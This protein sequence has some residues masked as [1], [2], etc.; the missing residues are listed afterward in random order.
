MKFWMKFIKFLLK[1]NRFFKSNRY[2]SRLLL[3]QILIAV[4]AL[5]RYFLL[6][7]ATFAIATALCLPRLSTLRL[8]CLHCRGEIYP[9]CTDKIYRNARTPATVKFLCPSEAIYKTSYEY[10]F[11]NSVKILKLF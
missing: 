7:R 1:I 5:S 4:F 8:A 3:R 2:F 9:A 11:L 10:K 6:F